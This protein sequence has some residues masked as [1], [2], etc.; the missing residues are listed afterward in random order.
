MRPFAR[1]YRP[2]SLNELIG[3]NDYKTILTN[4]L[5]LKNFSSNYLLTGTRGIG[6]TTLARIAANLFSCASVKFIN[7][8]S[9]TC[10]KCESCINNHADILEIDGASHN[11]I[12][13]I[14]NLI[15]IANQ[16]P[17]FSHRKVIIIDEVHMLSN[18]AFN[19]MLKLLEEPPSHVIFIFA[20]TEEHKIPKTIQSRCNR[21]D[22]LSY[23]Q[24]EIKT[25]LIN[26]TEKENITFDEDFLNYIIQISDDSVREALFHLD[27]FSLLYNNDLKLS[28]I[29]DFYISNN[30]IKE[31][32]LSIKNKQLHKIQ[33][34]L[35]KTK[36][37]VNEKVFYK[38]LIENIFLDDYSEIA[39]QM[40]DI[41]N[42]HL[43]TYSNIAYINILSLTQKLLHKL[44][45]ITDFHFLQDLNLS[46]KSTEQETKI[47]E[48]KENTNATSK[49]L[50]REK[51]DQ[52]TQ[53]LERENLDQETRN[54]ERENLDQE[55]R[56]LEREKLDQETQNLEREKL[57]QETQNLQREKLD[58]ETRNLTTQIKKQSTIVK[59]ELK[60][61]H[62]KIK[63]SVKETLNDSLYLNS[64]IDI[65]IPAEE[66]TN[67]EKV[68]NN[69]KFDFLKKLAKVSNILF[70]TI[71]HHCSIK[72]I[73]TNNIYLE[74]KL[75]S[76]N[77][78]S[79]YKQT[80]NEFEYNLHFDF[81][82]H[83]VSIISDIE[84]SFDIIKKT[85][86]LFDC[87]LVN[88]KL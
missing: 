10:N 62:K 65:S 88:I 25:I 1:Y 43:T 84:N 77:M 23:S 82:P 26:I 78:K 5:K 20:T 55:T 66:S 29:K 85:K 42:A 7:K 79:Q 33:L 61:P 11:S 56:N 16:I 6:K 75:N 70:H 9:Q 3:M 30:E 58:Q 17:I 21:F 71:I 12:E 59:K 86:T 72:H 41:I 39:Y 48:I 87:K 37:I 69:T 18:A 31:F 81:N 8:L 34:F 2:S 74:T 4:T 46:L 14:K 60:M 83:I 53:N 51:L 76:A 63:S 35:M 45:N 80:L 68:D 15:D 54:L 64:L 32:V 28:H 57:D 73:D 38:K 22:I 50:E 36:S 44:Y 27:K 24:E 52:E 19:V 13:D 47:S 67:V 49:A 40:Y